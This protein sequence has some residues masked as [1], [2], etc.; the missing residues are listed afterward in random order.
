M[1]SRSV[2]TL[3]KDC[4]HK[5]G[6]L[7][8]LRDIFSVQSKP[9]PHLLRSALEFIYRNR[10]RPSA[11]RNLRVIGVTESSISVTWD[12]TSD[13]EDGF[14]V[15]RLGGGRAHTDSVGQD[16]QTHTFNDLVS[17]VTFS[18]TVNAFNKG[19]KSPSNTVSATT[20]ASPVNLLLSYVL[21]T[22]ATPGHAMK[23]G[24]AAK[25]LGALI[26]KALK[27]LA[28]GRGLIPILVALQ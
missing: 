8:V 18:I 7:S 12:D 27:P 28:T 6:E 4:L 26:G 20:P 23:A 2:R 3:A 24:D 14:E 10:C 21:T 25:S 9:P 13:N 19:G 16:Q 5:T 15:T 11:P 1:P 22:S 17:G